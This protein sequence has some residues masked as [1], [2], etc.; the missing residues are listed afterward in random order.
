MENKLK[1]QIIAEFVVANI[2]VDEFEDFFAYNDLGIPLALSLKDDLCTITEKGVEVINET[3]SDLCSYL[4]IDDEYEYKSVD[5]FMSD[6]G[7]LDI[8]E[9]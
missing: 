6:I 4:N 1:A 2:G 3:Y 5:D 7:D 9:E 8:D